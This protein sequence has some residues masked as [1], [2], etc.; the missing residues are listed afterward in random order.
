M[1]LFRLRRTP[2]FVLFNTV[3]PSTILFLLEALVFLIPIEN[4]EKLSLGVTLMLSITVFQLVITD[5]VPKNSQ[6]FPLMCK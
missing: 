6:F 5:Y 3:M 1:C 2:T 4:G